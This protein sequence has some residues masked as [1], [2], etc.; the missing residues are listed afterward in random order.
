MQII[1]N[2]HNIKCDC[3]ACRNR[4][5]KAVKFDRVGIRGR[6]YFCDQCLNA[7]YTA[8][9]ESIVPKS[10]ETAKRKTSKGTK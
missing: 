1:E 7:L 9:G 4:A 10:V 2:K 6:M 8:I 3:G 5:T